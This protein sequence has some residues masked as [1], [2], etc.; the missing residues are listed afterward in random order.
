MFRPL[1]STYSGLTAAN[2]R[3]LVKSTYSQTSYFFKCHDRNDFL[4]GSLLVF[5][6][7]LECG[8][9]FGAYLFEIGLGLLVVGF[10]LVTS[11]SGLVFVFASRQEC[12][13]VG[14]VSTQIT[15]VHFEFGAWAFVK[16]RIIV[17]QDLNVDLLLL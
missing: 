8:V 9:E 16:D 5:C 12:N 10:S 11:L 15:F 3:F 6:R 13:Y 7:T 1:F 2:G 14:A 17:F 4:G